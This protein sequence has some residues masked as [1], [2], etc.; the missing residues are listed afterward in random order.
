MHLVHVNDG[1][2]RFLKLVLLLVQKQGKPRKDEQERCIIYTIK[3]M[4]KV[5]I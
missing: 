3:S 5:K 4:L 2:T 1:F